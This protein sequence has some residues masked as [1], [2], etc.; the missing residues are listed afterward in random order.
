[1][2]E[3]RLHGALGRDFGTTWKLEVATVRQAINA[4]CAMKPKFRAAVL[5]LDKTGMV[6]RVRT[7]TEDLIEHQL[8]MRLADGSRVDIIPIVRGASAGVRFV[9][10]VILVVVGVIFSETGA[11]AFAIK[12]GIMLMVGSV[13]EMLAPHPTKEK[14]ADDIKSWT[15]NGPLNTTDQ[16][17]PVPVIYGEVLTGGVP[18]SAGLTTSRGITAPLI[19]PSAQIGGDIDEVFRFGGPVSNGQI[20][21]YYSVSTQYM[22][23]PFTYSWTK[24]GFSGASNVVIDGD[25]ATISLTLTYDISLEQLSTD[26]GTL[27]ATVNGYRVNGDG[28]HA[29]AT[30]TLTPVITLDTRVPDWS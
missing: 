17:N 26:T 6:F 14:T 5:A 25:G 10:G 12:L 1:M 3:L 9:I 7:K 18:I 23:E 30:A 15:I 24:S 22:I 4:I 8:P 16:G 20:V 2:I 21:L 27:Q 11:G 19:A 13:A 29:S 28:T